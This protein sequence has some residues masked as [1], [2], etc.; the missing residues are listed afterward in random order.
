[1]HRGK[2]RVVYII[3]SVLVV[4]IIM[5]LGNGVMIGP[6]D[7]QNAI[8]LEVGLW[9]PGTTIEQTFIASMDNLS[10]IDFYTDSY[11]PWDS[12]YLDCRL[13]EIHTEKNPF[14]LSYEFIKNNRKEIHYKR[15]NGWM[16][17]IHM[18]NSFSFPPIPQS[19]NKAYLFT[20]QSPGLKKGGTSI[21][22]ASSSDRYM[23]YGNLFVNGERK[24]GDLAFRLLYTRP[25][26]WLI[27]RSFER[28]GLQKPAL[29][30]SPISYYVLIGVYLILLGLLFYCLLG[31]NARGKN[32]EKADIEGRN[33]SQVFSGLKNRKKQF[34]TFAI[35]YAILPISCG[36]VWAQKLY[37]IFGHTKKHTDKEKLRIGII[38]LQKIG[39]LVCTTP[40]FRELRTHYPHAHLTAIV[41]PLT[42]G[43]LQYNPHVDDIILYDAST[44]ES[45][46][47]N[48]IRFIRTLMGKHLDWSFN[49]SPNFKNIVYT[50]L[51][52]IPNRICLRSSLGSR[53]TKSV[54]WANS[55]IIDY[56][57]HTSAM[58]AYLEALRFI[59]ISDYSTRKEIYM[60]PDDFD[61]A[62]NFL[63]NRGVYSQD[64]VIALH[65]F[66]GVPIK[67]WGDEKFI[68][69]AER[70][71]GR[72]NAKVLLIGASSDREKA[73]GMQKRTRYSLINACGEFT[74]AQ[75]PA[76]LKRCQAFISGDT[77]P[78][79]IA[80]AIGVPVVNIA[81][82]CDLNTQSPDGVYEI[83]QKSLDCVPCSFIMNAPRVCKRGDRKCL[84]LI[85]VDDVLQALARLIPL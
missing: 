84:D 54:Y 15:L 46:F 11:H 59:G 25:R 56:N 13:F 16:L 65:P 2:S 31:I 7:N 17:S 38:Q 53:M 8:D 20:I 22:L 39:D 32:G 80:N 74:L 51:A 48:E 57:S 10:R 5:F 70:L 24:E 69:L 19:K 64:T 30:S 12:P 21:L 37:K 49:F 4:G 36:I 34:S 75:L 63:K 9:T 41:L 18:F 76:L 50:C 68:K 14:D 28:L 42:Q 82:P 72:Y 45:S 29:F 43:V 44:L 23:Y 40:V 6:K 52:L 79:Y 60:T 78:L 1:M 73:Q 71:V 67:E 85:T 62:D 47:W 58:K 77:G 27:Q 83:V 66:A 55:G 26:S 35:F 33:S 61:L 3:V 81:G